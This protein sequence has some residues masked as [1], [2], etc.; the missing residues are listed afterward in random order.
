MFFPWERITVFQTQPHL[1]GHLTLTEKMRKTLTTFSFGYWKLCQYLRETWGIDFL[2]FALPY[3]VINTH[4]YKFGNVAFLLFAIKEISFH[5]VVTGK[6]FVF[7][8][9]KSYDNKRIPFTQF[10]IQAAPCT[11]QSEQYHRECPPPPSEGKWHSIAFDS[12]Q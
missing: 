5:K 12:R 10:Y 2:K 8:V 4:I 6:N 3:D 11:A 1:A 9:L 7:F